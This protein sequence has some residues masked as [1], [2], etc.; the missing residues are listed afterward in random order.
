MKTPL[1]A[2]IGLVAG[3]LLSGCSREQTNTGPA[4]TGTIQY[5]APVN[6][7][8][9]AVLELKLTDV[10]VADG[11]ALEIA[12]LTIDDLHAL[13]YQYRLPYDSTKIDAQHRYMVDA[14]IFIDKQ[15]RFSTD[16]A[17][18]VLTQGSGEQRDIAVITIG[19]NE[20]TITSTANANVTDNLFQNELRTGEEVSLY[21]AGLED[22]HILWLEEDRSNGTPVPLHARYEFKGAL[23]MH[24]ADSSPLEI[25]FDERGRPTG[26]FKDKQA[27]K[28]STQASAIDAVRNRA[29]LLRS[30]ALAARETRAHREATGG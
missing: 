21:K 27:L 9:N 10:S 1:I 16:T 24:Y 7:D 15:L 6:L 2:L 3:M 19:E 25:K 29:E 18:A 13:P 28:V 23:L 4:I 11:P 20:S 12:K 26:V 14:R 5:R 22:G 30:H 17:Y 8:A